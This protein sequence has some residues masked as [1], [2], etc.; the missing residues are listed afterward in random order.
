MK[1]KK[2]RSC[3]SKK[4]IKLF[5]LGSMC[6][7]GKFPKEN[8]NIK[9]EPIVLVMCNNCKLVQLGHSFDLNYLYGPDYG[10]KQELIKQCSTM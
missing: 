1:L 4:L 10:I 6:F 8:Q 5:S 7:T 9:K 2:C 3:K